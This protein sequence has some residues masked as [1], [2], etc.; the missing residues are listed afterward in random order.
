MEHNFAGLVGHRVGAR[1]RRVGL[2]LRRR[3]TQRILCQRHVK[4]VE[5]Q[6]DAR[7]VIGLEIELAVELFALGSAVAAVAVDGEC[8]VV[9]HQAVVAHGVRELVVRAVQ[10]V[11]AHVI[12]VVRQRHFGR[13]FGKGLDHAA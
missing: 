2:K 10:A 9:G 7:L 4:L 1:A 6:V 12:L 11:V 3:Q 5:H 8:A 13:G